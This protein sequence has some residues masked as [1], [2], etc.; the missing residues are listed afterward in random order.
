MN[1]GIY[2]PTALMQAAVANG[3]RVTALCQAAPEHPTAAGLEVRARIPAAVRVVE[4]HFSPAD[5]SGQLSPS[6]DGGFTNIDSIIDAARR[7]FG[8]DV[9][10]LVLATGPSFAEFVAAM[11][12]GARYGVPYALDYRDEWSECPM[13][14]V[15]KGN[16]DRFWESR[17]LSNAG[18]VTFTTEAQ[19]QHQIGTFPSLRAE[20]TDVVPNGWDEPPAGAQ[21][22]SNGHPSSARARVVFLGNVSIYEA[23]DFLAVLAATLAARPALA[24]RIEVVFVGM[25]E[26]KDVKAITDFPIPGVVS[27]VAQVPLSEAQRIMRSAEAL[28]YLNPAR[29]SRYVGGKAWEYIAA[30]RPV[31]VYGEGGESGAVFERY[32]PALRVGRSNPAALGEA[33]ERIASRPVPSPVD[34]GFLRETA[35]PFRAAQ[36]LAKLERLIRKPQEL[37]DRFTVPASE[38]A[39]PSDPVFPSGLSPGRGG[40]AAG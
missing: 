20:V 1:G 34:P 27:S 18:L 16:S 19:R 15:Q 7:T 39:G 38:Y 11:V 4:W 29:F 6:L 17:V 31:L 3:W 36:H 33:L 14:F 25:K 21:A 26:P 8:R 30:G 32:G 2:R 23:P 9:P 5:V 13:H 10:D 22:S 28:L 35:R 37:R 12:L 40:P 24:S